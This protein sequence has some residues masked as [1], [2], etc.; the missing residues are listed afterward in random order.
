MNDSY[1]GVYSGACPLPYW[2][3]L[4]VTSKYH[5]K[6]SHFKKIKYTVVID[7]LGFTNLVTFSFY[8]S[9]QGTPCMASEDFSKMRLVMSIE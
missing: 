5:G 6:H 7:L 1:K 9:E 8:Q 4:C 3:S 2:F